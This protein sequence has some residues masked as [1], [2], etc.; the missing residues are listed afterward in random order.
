MHIRELGVLP[1]KQSAA[2]D[3]I[4]NIHNDIMHKKNYIVSNIL[5]S[6]IGTV[7]VTTCSVY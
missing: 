2:F 7:C 3:L 5:R 1:Q 6:L 4:N